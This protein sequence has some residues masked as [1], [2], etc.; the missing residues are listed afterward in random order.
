MGVDKDADGKE[1]DDATID[2][3]T[4]TPPTW[5]K[6][7]AYYLGARE[8]LYGIRDA[9]LPTAT[10]FKTVLSAD[11][12]PTIANRA[13][14]TNIELGR[15]VDNGPDRARIVSQG[16]RVSAINKSEL[17]NRLV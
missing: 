11:H 4:V 10:E 16:I 14:N 12:N 8:F 15:L 2:P 6:R 3:A 7:W 13:A 17:K 5:K 9:G 1:D